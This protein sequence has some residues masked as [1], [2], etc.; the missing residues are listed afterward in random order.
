MIFENSSLK[1]IQTKYEIVQILKKLKNENI[2]KLE[3]SFHPSQ[4]IQYDKMDGES[5]EEQIHILETL[6]QMG[7]VSGKVSKSIEK[8]KFCGSYRFYIN[9]ACTLCKSAQIIRGAT[10]KHDSCG[11]IDFD[12]KYLRDDNSL[13]CEKC[14]KNLKAIGIDHSKLGY[15]YKCLE[16]KSILPNISNQY[17][18]VNCGNNL[19]NDELSIQYL[20]AYSADFKKISDILNPNAYLLSVIEDLDRV[21]IKSELSASIIGTSGMLHV[22]EL[23]TYDE[24]KLPFIALDILQSDNKIEDLFVLSFVAKCS[25]VDIPSKILLSIPK[26]NESIKALANINGIIVIES[27]TMEEATLDLVNAITEIHNNSNSSGYTN[28]K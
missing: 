2:T 22:F 17:W 15:F 28:D 6:E 21:G 16:C 27:E 20:K 7:L 3:P 14:N 11:N 1:N 25:D 13:K 4:G 24:L 18:C 26:A 23:V 19:S 5:L 9:F 12:Y 8:C 10:I